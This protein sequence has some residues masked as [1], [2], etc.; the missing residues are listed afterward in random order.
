[1]ADDQVSTTWQTKALPVWRPRAGSRL[2]S[3]RLR[4]NV[5]PRRVLTVEA[6]QKLLAGCEII[7]VLNGVDLLTA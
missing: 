3:A 4:G 7:A 6:L 2:V 1:M 5:Q